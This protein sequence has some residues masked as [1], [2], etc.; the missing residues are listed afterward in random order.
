MAQ[1]DQTL[2]RTVKKDTETMVNVHANSFKPRPSMLNC[3]Q[4]G[5]VVIEITSPPK[6]GTVTTRPTKT[7][8]KDCS[9][10]LMGTGIY[11]KPK[12]GFTGSDTFTYVRTEE[13]MRAVSKA[14]GPQGSRVINI[15]VQP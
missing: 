8:D 10:E 7:K 2:K 11:Y 9:N 5:T 13:N 3:E 1:S 12:P 6:N 4:G 15:T 14:G